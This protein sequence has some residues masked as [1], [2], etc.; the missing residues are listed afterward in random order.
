MRWIRE[1]IEAVGLS[2]GRMTAMTANAFWRPT[3]EPVWFGVSRL[4]WA[5]ASMAGGRA[6]SADKGKAFFVV[7]VERIARGGHRKCV[8]I[9]GNSNRGDTPRFVHPL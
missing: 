4:Y 8:R 9:V 5:I 1:G 2:G 6:G 7:M 3:K